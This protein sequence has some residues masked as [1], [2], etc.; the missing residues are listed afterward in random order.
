MAALPKDI[1]HAEAMAAFKALVGQ[2]GAGADLSVGLDMGP[3]GKPSGV[4]RATFWPNGLTA[5]TGR[6]QFGV[7]ADSY[8][9]LLAAS[10]AAWAERSDLHATNTIREM[11]LAII[12]ITAD[13]GECT[14]AALRAKFDGADVTRYGDRAC[15]A[16]TEMASNGPF[17]IVKLSG[18]NDIAA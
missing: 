17:S 15:E 5:S 13:L 11:A 9:E 16:A 14:D 6:T 12:S 8:R 1:T 3:Y 4:L 2:M 18:A 7:A 10:E